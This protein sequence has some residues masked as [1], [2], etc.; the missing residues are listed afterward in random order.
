[1]PIVRL[2]G[3]KYVQIARKFE[4]QTKN[5]KNTQEQ[6]LFSKLQKNAETEY[7]KRYNFKEIS[8]IK[9]FQKRVPIVQYENIRDFIEREKSGEK[10]VLTYQNPEIFVTTS[11]T[12]GD[13]KFI[14][15]TRDFF[16]EYSNSW[17]IWIAKSIKNHVGILFGRTLSIVSPPIEGY[18]SA[19]I[20]YGA[21]TGLSLDAPTPFM[22]LFYGVPKE[23]FSLESPTNRQYVALRIGLE[24]RI[25]LITTANP[26]TIKNLCIMADKQKEKLIR[27]IYNGTISIETSENEKE[28]L[29]KLRLKRNKKRAKKLE[30]IVEDTGHLYPKDFWPNLELIGCWKGGTLFLYL[31]SFKKYFKENMPVRDLGLI[32]SEGRF[33]T[34]ISDEG[35]AGIL[36]IGSHLYEF[37]P[38]SEIGSKNPTT[39]PAWEIG[40]GK[41]FLI[42]TTSAGLYRY[43]INDVVEVVNYHNQTPVIRFL[44]KGNNISSLTGEKISENQ[45]I[46]AMKRACKKNNLDI[47]TFLVCPV[48]GDPPKYGLFLEELEAEKGETYLKSLSKDFDYF[49]RELNIEYDSK[50]KDRLESVCMGLLPNKTFEMMKLKFLK[51]SPKDTQYKHRFL[52]KEINFHK[53]LNARFI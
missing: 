12:T 47:D 23:V 21:M 11:G 45:I 39:L 5:L 44:N 18:T 46:E 53:E 52:R 10:N 1:M 42:V 16:D 25:S 32:A 50:R 13:P 3:R 34:P 22:R 24:K 48:W 51:K 43:D 41:Y 40:L 30:A 28:I 15:I 14:P 27:D 19:G 33:S 38:E 7:G 8:S 9:D 26:S 6:V 31:E 36:D 35:S 20:P 4:Q 37:I 49:L 29:R 2:L 17:N